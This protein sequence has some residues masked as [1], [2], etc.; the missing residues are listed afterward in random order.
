[1]AIKSKNAFGSKANIETAKTNG[2]IDEYDILYL[3]DGEIAWL[4]KSKN[5]V[6]NT[7]RTQEDIVVS[8]VDSFDETDGNKIAAGKTLEEAIK[9]VANSVLPKAQEKTLQSAK[10]YADTV[11]GGSVDVVEF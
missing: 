4:D 10:D 2:M 11:A 3:D 5:T 1:M 7:P 6:I 9:I 8:S